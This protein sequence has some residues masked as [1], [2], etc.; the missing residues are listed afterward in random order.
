MRIENPFVLKNPDFNCCAPEPCGLEAA[1]AIS[2]PASG[3]KSDRY[4]TLTF[5][6]DNVSGY[7][8]RIAIRIDGKKDWFTQ[9]EVNEIC[10]QFAGDYEADTL[11]Q[12]FQHVGAM[13]SVTHGV[14]SLQTD[15][16]EQ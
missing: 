7:P 2:D 13:L 4:S 3:Y 15:G 12:F 11:V 8:M 9:D 1:L 6:T 16:D 14:C 5:R 10:I